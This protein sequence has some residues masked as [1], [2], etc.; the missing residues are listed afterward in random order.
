[1]SSSWLGARIIRCELPIGTGQ[2]RCIVPGARQ[3]PPNPTASTLLLRI[4]E[5]ERLGGE[6]R[7]QPYLQRITK[8]C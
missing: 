8:L 7:A 5:A 6:Y 4:R 2:T 1:M 3:V